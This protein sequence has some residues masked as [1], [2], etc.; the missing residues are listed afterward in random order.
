MSTLADLQSVAGL[1][2]MAELA[3]KTTLVLALAALAAATLRGASAAVRH[4]VWCAALV[5]VLCLPLLTLL[6]P[7][8]EVPLLPAASPAGA[9][10]HQVAAAPL[11]E[12]AWQLQAPPAE[13][14]LPTDSRRPS[15]VPVHT[16]V[17]LVLVAGALAGLIWMAIAFAAVAL[18]GRRAQVVREPAWLRLARETAGRLGVRRRVRLLRSGAATMPAT[19]GLLRPAVVLPSCAD[20][21]PADRRRAVLGHELAHLKRLDV[22]TQALGLVAC[23]LLWWHPAVWYAARRMRMESERA[24]DDMVL[25]SGAP[26]AEY[27]AH[28]LEIA[29]WHRDSRLAAPALVSMARRSQLES[30]LLAVLDRARA[31]TGPSLAAAALVAI[32]ALAVVV[33]LSAL[34]AAEA[35]PAAESTEQIANERAPDASPAVRSAPAE[36]AAPPPEP[37]AAG[38][39]VESIAAP[40]DQPRSHPGGG[41]QA[42]TLRVPSVDDL[43]RMRAVGVTP[44]YI[45]AM[46][47]AGLGALSI[48]Q[49]VSLRAVGVTPAY[50]EGLNGAGHRQ[51][52][53]QAL[54]SLR[55][56]GVT[57]GYLQELSRLGLSGLTLEQTRR[58][59]A[60]GVTAA[61]LSGMRELGVQGLD[62]E[63]L[64]RLRAVGVTP[65]YIRELGEAGITARDP[66][67]LVRLRASG[68][69]RELIDAAGRTREAPGARVRPSPQPAAGA[70][71]MEGT[72]RPV[73]RP[74]PR[75]DNPPRG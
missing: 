14:S 45:A 22:L 71:Q 28:L 58:L 15:G 11:P 7:G 19:W 37:A 12:A 16:L 36:G 21:W 35:Q 50:I 70:P 39:P 34:R 4:L 43:I 2:F 74:E 59:R 60:V 10:L 26:A 20:H 56:V 42:D 73:P 53:V 44:R 47:E 75:P 18:L 25:R 69:G 67:Q 65:A 46:E 8:W 3:L 66:D 62:A 49:L 32:T 31:R 64:I 9:A 57:Q 72:G 48:D 24:C 13:P 51:I 5:A 40:V 38:E 23:A 55:A 1:A 52:P 33:P 29:R 6:L 30:R 61:Y 27:A 63:T 68:V 54:I 17:P 41:H